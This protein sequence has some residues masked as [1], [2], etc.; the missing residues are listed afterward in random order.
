MLVLQAVTIGHLE[1]RVKYDVR[2]LLNNGSS[3]HEIHAYLR[4]IGIL[5]SDYHT[6]VAT[7]KQLDEYRINAERIKASETPRIRRFY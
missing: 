5:N 2:K 4:S 6:Y 1:D 7:K 3:N